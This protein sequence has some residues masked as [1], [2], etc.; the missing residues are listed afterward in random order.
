VIISYRLVS[1]FL[2]KGKINLSIVLFLLCF[3]SCIWKP[4]NENETTE[5]TPRIKPSAENNVVRIDSV[6]SGQFD[7]EIF[8]NGKASATKISEVLFGISSN[9]ENI[10]IKNGDNVIKGQVLAKL[11]TS[12][13]RNRIARYKSALN[14]SLIDLDDRLIDYGFRLRDS[15]KVPEKI[16]QLAKF[17]SGYTNALFDY[18]EAERALK[19]TV[20]TAPFSGKIADLEARASNSSSSFKRLCKVIDDSQM[21][22][23]FNVLESELDYIS[24]NTLIEVS[25]FG[26]EVILRG[27]VRQINPIIDNT[28]MIKVT[29]VVNNFQS[30]LLDGMSVKVKLR[31]AISAK[32]FVRKESVL[33]RQDRNVIFTYLDGRA[34]W[35]YVET[36]YQNSKYVIITSGLKASE[37]IIV[38]NNANLADNQLVK[39][40][41]D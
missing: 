1:I 25:P 8:S 10:N 22:I 34:K 26:S 17:K 33:H 15:L 18:Q 5:E 6:R 23:E 11:E 28:G 31:K 29:A 41:V 24:N 35:N 7:I 19:Q 27:Y 38:D 37:K 16:M 3:S 2:D 39:L 12:E 4:S 20:I 32:M 9:I 21:L 14:K 40:H 13:I 36:G 30:N